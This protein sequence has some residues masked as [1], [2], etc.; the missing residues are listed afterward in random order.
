MIEL[1]IPA[2]AIV[3]GKIIPL[4]PNASPVTVDTATAPIAIPE[5]IDQT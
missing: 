3:S 2:A 5:I 4:I 1:K